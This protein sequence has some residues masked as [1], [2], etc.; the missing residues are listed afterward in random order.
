M[1]RHCRPFLMRYYSEDDRAVLVVASSTRTTFISVGRTSVYLCGE[2]LSL[3][4]CFF[5]GGG[6]QFIFVGRTSVYLC[7]EDL[8]LS[9]WGGPQFICVERTPQFISVGRTSVYLCGEDLNLAL[10]GGPQFISLEKTELNKSSWSLPG[11]PP[12]GGMLKKN[13]E[14][15]KERK[16]KS[17]PKKKKPPPSQNNK[18]EAEDLHIHVYLQLFPCF[19]VGCFYSQL[20]MWTLSLE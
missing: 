2:D 8:S 10:W 9:L 4:L 5:F 14:K 6:P 1:G 18:K 7:G 12:R 15:K 13:K 19:F 3:S 20:C 17:S 16:M 11:K